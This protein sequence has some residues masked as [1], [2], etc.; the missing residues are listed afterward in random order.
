MDMGPVKARDDVD[1]VLHFEHPAGA[2]GW[3]GTVYALI[4]DAAVLGSLVFGMVYLWALAPAWPPSV[5]ATVPLWAVAAAGGCWLAAAT[6]GRWA[7]RFLSTPSAEDGW[8]VGGLALHAAALAALVAALGWVLASLPPASTHAQSALT[9]MLLWY[10]AVHAGAALLM[11][12][13]LALRWKSGFVSSRRRLEPKVVWLFGHYSLGSALLC[14]IL[15]AL[16]G[17]LG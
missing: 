8:P 7:R 10:A 9:A 1:L 15:A 4:A 3:H 5:M 13:F 16:P 6:A 14:L 2:P 11:S 12:L 17:W